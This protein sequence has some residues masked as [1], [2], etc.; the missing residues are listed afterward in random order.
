MKRKWIA[1]PSGYVAP[2]L[3]GIWAS[4]PYLHNGSVPTLWHLLHPS[5]RPAVWKRTTQQYDPIRVGLPVDAWDQLPADVT[6]AAVKRTY[7]DT[8]RFGMRSSG[9]DY[10]NQLDEQE[11]RE[12]LEYLKTL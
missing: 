6:D 11:K 8:S 9:H 10:P 12:V 4:A 2:P 3:D 1:N 7:F 5:E